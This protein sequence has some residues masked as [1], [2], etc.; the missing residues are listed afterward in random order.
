MSSTAVQTLYTPE[1]YLTLERK[2]EYKSEYINGYIIAM[3]G[4]SREHNLVAGNIFRELSTQL[5]GRPCE[6]YI[7]DMRVKVSPTGLYTYPDV[8]VA[9]EEIRFEDAQVDTLLNPTVIV[10][11]LS[12]S[13]E[14]CDR[15]EKFGH[16]QRLDSLQEYLMVAQDR[17]CIEHYGRHGNRW[18]LSETRDLDETVQLGSIGCELMLREVYDKVQ[19]PEENNS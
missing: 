18:E 10:E 13:T 4:A 7:G 14:A 11:A 9:C 17:V 15:G 16:Y 5:K 2:A 1:Q 3:S 8:V 19:F 6:A 12:P